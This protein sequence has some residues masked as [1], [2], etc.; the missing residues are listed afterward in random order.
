MLEVRDECYC[1]LGVLEDK[2]NSWGSK[3][4]QEQKLRGKM[5]NFSKNKLEIIQI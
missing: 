5:H 4:Y 1:Y 2:V 3:S